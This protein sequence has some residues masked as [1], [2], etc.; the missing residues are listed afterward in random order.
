MEFGISASIIQ[1]AGAGIKLSQTLYAYGEGVSTADCRLKDMPKDVKF[2]TKV[3]KELGTIFSKDETAKLV[4]DQ[5]IQTAEDSISECSSIFEEL[6][7]AVQKSRRRTMGQWLFPF[8]EAKFQLLQSNLDRLKSTLQLLMNV[9]TH[10]L[11]AAQHNN[12]NITE[13]LSKKNIVRAAYQ[14]EKSVQNHPH[15]PSLFNLKSKKR[16]SDQNEADGEDIGPLQPSIENHDP[17]CR[18]F[19]NWNHANQRLL[20]L[21]EEFQ[22]DLVENPT[23]TQYDISPTYST[24][25]NSLDKIFLPS[26]E[27]APWGIPSHESKKRLLLARD[28]MIGQGLLPTSIETHHKDP[29]YKDEKD[30]D[31]ITA[32]PELKHV[33][34]VIALL[35]TIGTRFYY[36]PGSLGYNFGE[37]LEMGFFIATLTIPVLLIV[38]YSYK[39]I[40]KI[41][42]NSRLPA[43]TTQKNSLGQSSVPD[44]V[45]RFEFL[46]S[47]PLQH[48]MD[49]RTTLPIEPKPNNVVYQDHEIMRSTSREPTTVGRRKFSKRRRHLSKDDDLP[50]VGVEVTPM[51]LSSSPPQPSL[52]DVDVDNDAFSLDFGPLHSED[53]LE[54]FDFDFFLGTNEDGLNF[55][56]GQPSFAKDYPEKL[57]SKYGHTPSKVPDEEQEKEVENQTNKEEKYDEKLVREL[58]KK[59]TKL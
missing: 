55:A 33:F 59:Y 50:E 34:V 7:T 45:P 52:P 27:K 5:A 21:V 20:S 47:G 8:K 22:Q 42:W 11:L 53:V 38:Y 18:S 43:M 2:T 39:L 54:N 25:R 15:E 56:F 57:N 17:K 41:I 37:L 32:P 24:I 58:L 16:V 46:G 13:D 48:I 6:G 26:H 19:I 40:T 4:S 51:G 10:A 3:M 35:L 44:N 23:K 9:L 14:N 29:V 49:D 1:V 30:L 36:L 12:K 28:G 31:R